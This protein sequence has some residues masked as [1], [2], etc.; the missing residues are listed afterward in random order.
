MPDCQPF[1]CYK[2]FNISSYCT[3]SV[4]I[5]HLHARSH[6]WQTL[7]PRNALL[8]QEELCI[9]TVEATFNSDQCDIT[10]N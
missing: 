9:G 3:I 1:H 2:H 5:N 4:L 8:R 10:E 7:L 6:L